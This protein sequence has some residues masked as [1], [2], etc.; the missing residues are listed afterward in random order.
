MPQDLR[1]AHEALDRAMD[2]IFSDKPFNSEEER[3][4]ALL[5]MYRKMTNEE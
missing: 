5:E 2:K 1:K 4:R 3:Q